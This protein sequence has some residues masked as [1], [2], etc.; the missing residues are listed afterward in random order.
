MHVLFCELMFQDRS[1]SNGLYLMA[2]SIFKTRFP[3]SKA[4]V[5]SLGLLYPLGVVILG[6]F[7]NRTSTLE[8]PKQCLA[9]GQGRKFTYFLGGNCCPH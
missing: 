3:Q 2:F 6:V 9:T 1:G 8:T 7:A 5:N 4:P